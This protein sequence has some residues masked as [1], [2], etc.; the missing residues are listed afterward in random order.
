MYGSS[1]P[2]GVGQITLSEGSPKTTR[3]NRYLHYNP[4]K[5]KRPKTKE[6]FQAFQC[7]QMI[8]P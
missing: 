6:A 3:K 7:C 2:L 8:E 5:I 4:P 1:S